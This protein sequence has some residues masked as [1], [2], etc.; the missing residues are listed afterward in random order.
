MRRGDTT[1]VAT[2]W[3]DSLQMSGKQKQIKRK[4]K[5]AAAQDRELRR[6]RNATRLELLVLGSCV[7]LSIVI[8]YGA[9]AFSVREYCECGHLHVNLVLVSLGLVLT[10]C[11]IAFTWDF[12]RARS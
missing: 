2:R 10:L 1:T 5:S 7:L 11:T 3:S 4:Q 12:C 9:I 8:D 6:R